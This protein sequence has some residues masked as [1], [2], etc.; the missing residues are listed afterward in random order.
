MCVCALSCVWLFETLW[1]IAQKVPLSMGLSQEEYWSGL[2]FPPPRD[3]PEPRDRTHIS[4]VSCIGS[5]LF[6]TE[7][8]PQKP[9]AISSHLFVV[10]IC[11]WRG[12]I[13]W[14]VYN[15]NVS[16]F[17]S[18]CAHCWNYL[19]SAVLGLHCCTGPFSSCGEW[20]PLFIE[21]HRLVTVV[22]SPVAEHRL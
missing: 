8:P 6:T 9:N 16:E 12:E 20:G 7:P 3:L 1:A 2:P 14:L 21:V 5:R 15:G 18:A 4:S 17:F 22:T 13:K 10:I 11:I 19:F